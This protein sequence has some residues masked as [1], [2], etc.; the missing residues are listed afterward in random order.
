MSDQRLEQMIRE[1]EEK[2]LQRLAQMNDMKQML[3]EHENDLARIRS[4]TAKVQ[5]E[6]AQA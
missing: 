6:Y 3:F 4:T 2:I 5:R 1:K